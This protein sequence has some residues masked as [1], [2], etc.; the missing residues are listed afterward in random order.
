MIED[1]RLEKRTQNYKKSSNLLFFISDV[2]EKDCL[3]KRG[4]EAGL[5]FWD[6]PILSP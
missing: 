6:K 1:K 5:E 3:V 4:E 2:N